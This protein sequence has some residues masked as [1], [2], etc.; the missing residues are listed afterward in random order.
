MN[1]RKLLG[2]AI[3]ALLAVVLMAFC[4]GAIGVWWAGPVLTLAVIAFVAL[5]W[6]A[7]SLTID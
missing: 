4:S 6:L 3:F 5:M 7:T 1:T 2:W